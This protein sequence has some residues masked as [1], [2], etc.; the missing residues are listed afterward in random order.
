M[1]LSRPPISKP[2]F[3]THQSKTKNIDQFSTEDIMDLAFFFK[4]FAQ[5]FPIEILDD[6]EFETKTGL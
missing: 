1:A 2:L 3:C 4:H 6:N 5:S